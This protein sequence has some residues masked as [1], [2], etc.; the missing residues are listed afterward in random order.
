M[1]EKDVY[2]DKHIFTGI[3][4]DIR[5]SASDCV[6]PDNAL[7]E[8]GQL[9]TFNAGIK[10]HR[11]LEELYRTDELYRC[12]ASESLPQAFLKMRDSMIVS[13][14]A[15]SES[16]TVERINIGGIQKR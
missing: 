15:S 5:N 8:V 14:R 9:D 13:D 16:L 12:E 1:A 7:K 3:V 11:I 6:F 10:M 4:D 2:I